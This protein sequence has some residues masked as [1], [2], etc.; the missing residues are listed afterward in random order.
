MFIMRNQLSYILQNAIF[1]IL[2][3]TISPQEREI[4]SALSSVEVGVSKVCR[5]PAE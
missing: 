5:S 2:Q 1:C 4:R 3:Y